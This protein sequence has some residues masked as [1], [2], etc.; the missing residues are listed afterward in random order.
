M[1]SF[2]PGTHS[3]RYHCAWHPVHRCSALLSSS[4]PCL[5]RPYILCCKNKQATFSST[6]L[7]LLWLFKIIYLHYRTL[8]QRDSSNVGT[9]LEP[10][11]PRQCPIPVLARMQQGM[12]KFTDEPVTILGIETSCD[13]TAVGVVDVTR[14]VLGQAK[15]SQ[16]KE[17]KQ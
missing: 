11:T 12:G 2:S 5:D 6:F 8:Y 10:N 17:H 1:S 4:C 9:T 16:I 7:C 13:D 3:A 14:R 15:A